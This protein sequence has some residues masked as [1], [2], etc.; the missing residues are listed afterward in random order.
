M[1]FVDGTDLLKELSHVIIKGVQLKT[2]KG[3][4]ILADFFDCRES[5]NLMLNLESLKDK[6]RACVR[7][8]GLTEIDH[9]FY[10]FP[11]S[12]VTGVILLAESHFAIHTWPEKK[13]LTLDIFICNFYSENT[14]KAKKLYQFLKQTFSPDRLNLQEIDRD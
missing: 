9:L 5:I 11:D 8:S 3:L 14:Q 10:Q 6:C 2:K 12:G 1:N 13:Y 4:H 7:E